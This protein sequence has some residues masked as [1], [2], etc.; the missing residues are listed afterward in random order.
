MEGRFERVARKDSAK[1]SSLMFAVSG[2]IAYRR[3][4]GKN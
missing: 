4:I 2:Y 3:I 1:E